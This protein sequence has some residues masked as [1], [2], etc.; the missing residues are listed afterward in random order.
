MATGC[1]V[2]VTDLQSE[3][4]AR[5]VEERGSFMVIR[6]LTSGAQM[7]QET[8]LVAR[9]ALLPGTR[10]KV[11]VGEAQQDAVITAAKLGRDAA[12]GLLVYGHKRDDGLEGPLREDAIIAVPQPEDAVEQLA[13]AAFNDLR[14]PMGKAKGVGGPDPWGPQTLGAREQVLAWR[15][16]AWQLTGGVVGLAAARVVPLPHQLI[17]ARR[18]LDDRQVRFLLADEVGLGKTIEAGLVIQSLLAI[19]PT[20]RVL[21]V[22]PGALISQWFLELYVRFGGRRF[23]MLDAERLREWDGNPWGDDKGGEQF[24]LTSSRALED[25]D[26]KAALR[27]ATSKWDMLVVDECHRMR[28]GGILYKRIAVVSKATPHVL[29]LSATPARGHADAYLG[30][31]ALLQPSVWKADDHAGFAGR[32]AAHAPVATLLSRTITADAAALPA[33]AKEWPTVIVG[34]TLLSERAA[35]MAKDPAARDALVAYVREH[36]QLDRRVIRNRRRVLEKL[37]ATTGVR[38]FAP[39]TRS[40]ELVT[41]E[42]DAAEKAVRSALAAYRS[43]LVGTGEIAPRLA[44]WLL[45]VELACTCHP[46]VAERLLAMRAAVAE[47]P[48]SF[49]EYR[50]RAGDETMAQVLRSD[51]S[52]HEVATHTA[53]S[54]AC[55]CDPAIETKPLAALREAVESW[56]KAA[57]KKPTRRLAKLIDRLEA[58]WEENPDEKVLVFTGQSLAVEPLAEALSKALGEG[59]IETFG[60]HQDAGAREESARKFQLDDRCAVMVSDPLGGEGRNFQFVSVVAHHDLP[61]SLAAVEQRIGRVDRLGRDGDIPSWVLTCD[62]ENAV[63]AAWAALLDQAV[64]VFTALTS[65]LEFIAD[66]IEVDALTAALT[67]GGKAVRK[68]IATA[69]TLVT[70]ERATQDSADDEAFAT[71]AAA[72]AEAGALAASVAKAEVPAGAI[73]R[74]LRGMGGSAKREEEHPQPWSLRSRLSDEPDKG[75]FHRDAALARPDLGFFGIGHRLIDRLVA[76]AGAAQWCRASAWRRKSA[77][78]VAAWSGIRAVFSLAPDLAPLATAN[79][80]IEVLRRLLVVAPPVRVVVLVRGDDGVVAR[81]PV[82]CA[83]LA[84]PFDGKGGDTPASTAANRDAWTRPLIA[85]TPERITGWQDQIRRAGAAAKSFVE[86]SLAGERRRLRAVLDAHLS[87]GLAAAQSTAAATVLRVGANHPDA[88]RA[89]AEADE[90]QKQVEALQA[91]VDGAGFALEQIAYVAVV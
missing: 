89:Q 70:Q 32:L 24:V 45:Q 91:A 6:F 69:A 21:I 10:V 8:R 3:G 60:S 55:N 59:R 61:W 77:N 81:D 42:P 87:P 34:D 1:L 39:T 57:T 51:L 50:I 76:D 78:G 48:D 56:L 73:A 22:V 12:S 83:L 53:I 11:Q 74:W 71:D 33:I 67:G 13:T 9:Y 49:E 85:G 40:R 38:A 29:L 41:Y 88:K 54:A 18:I 27:F 16:A 47:D 79:L 15:D 37:A 72:Y 66:K 36:H 20:M 23:L 43:A 80:R 2:T 5:L 17:T 52:E 64:G 75:V 7:T 30:L 62:D 65:G 14:P 58:F 44:H 84:K 46:Q 90:E 68:T 28:P 4:L 82:L 86:Q 26:P 31:L 25:L 63:D 35:A 19:K